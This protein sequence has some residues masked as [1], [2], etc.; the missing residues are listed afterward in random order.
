MTD[1][2][3]IIKELKNYEYPFE[4]IVFEGGGAKGLAYIGVLEVSKLAGL[5]L[6]R[7]ICG[8]FPHVVVVVTVFRRKQ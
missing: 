2:A 6:G 5:G 4:N 3:D 8:A 1:Y 7:G